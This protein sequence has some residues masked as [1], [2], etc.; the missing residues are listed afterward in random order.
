MTRKDRVMGRDNQLPWSIPGDLKYFRATTLGHRLIM[1]RKTFESIG[2][3]ALP[4][5]ENWVLSTGEN[6]FP[7]GVRQFK[8]KESILEELQKLALIDKE[9]NIKTFVIGGSK[10]FEVFWNEIKEM[11][12]TWV[13]ESVAGDVR[14][15]ELDWKSFSLNYEKKESEPL[16]HTFT[17]YSKK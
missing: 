7:E 9:K 13:E 8:S 14:F 3:K 2:S 10:L 1:G 4:K 11:H 17:V 12:V 16:P 5:R 6:S 15:P